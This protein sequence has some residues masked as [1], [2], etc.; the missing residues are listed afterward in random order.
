MHSICLFFR[1]FL[2]GLDHGDLRLRE[3]EVISDELTVKGSHLVL[4]LVPV[5]EVDGAQIHRITRIV[6]LVILKSVRLSEGCFTIDNEVRLLFLDG[7][8][9]LNLRQVVVNLMLWN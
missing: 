9:L 4:V 7:W 5:V 8:E 3:E 2:L 6:P 1:F